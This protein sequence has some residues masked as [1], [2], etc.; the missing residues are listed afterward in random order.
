MGHDL[1]LYYGDKL[2]QVDL[3]TEGSTYAID[4][5]SNAEMCVTYNY[6][7]FIRQALHEDGI[8]W[9]YGKTAAE[10]IP[11]L[12]QAIVTLG[13]ERTTNYWDATP[14]NAGYILSVLLLWAR[15]H[16]DAIWNGD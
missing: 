10:T 8:M 1:G 14:G 4:G 16:P 9:L 2:A 11:A 13:T 6:S 12:E 3:H 7:R 15:E 5:V